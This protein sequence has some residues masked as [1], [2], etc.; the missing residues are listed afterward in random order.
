MVFEVID[1][2]SDDAVEEAMVEVFRSNSITG[3][4]D[5]SGISDS[6]GEIAFLM[7][8]CSPY[9]YRVYTDPALYETKVTIENN[10]VESANA[11]STFFL[12]EELKSFPLRRP[13]FPNPFTFEINRH[14]AR[15]TLFREP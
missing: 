13:S 4:P 15:S 2:Q 7:E 12:E 10:K 6:A 5:N 3:V 14:G 11:N 1:F 8:T 9:T